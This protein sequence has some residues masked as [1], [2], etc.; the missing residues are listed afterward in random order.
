M[1]DDNKEAISSSFSGYERNHLFVNQGGKAFVDLS[2][3]SG[4]DTLGDSR[5][6]A[7]LDYNR[8]GWPD[9][10]LVNANAPLFELFRNELGGSQ[11]AAG[12]KV[13]ALRFV[14]GNQRAQPDPDRS[15]RD[16]YGAVVTVEL[17][18]KRLVR[19]HRCGE[20]FAAQNSSTLLI[21][22]GDHPAASRVS[23]RW[24]SGHVQHVDNVAAGTLLTAYEDPLQAPDKKSFYRETY[25]IEDKGSRTATA[26]R[27]DP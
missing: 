27:P 3:V 15:C 14:G 10:A 9:I 11:M 17:G 20:G 24:P 25:R 23:V 26:P 8:D 6:F 16:G 5:S 12:H 2:G 13:L 7:V 21:G 1:T 4:L 19:E 22:I 18:D